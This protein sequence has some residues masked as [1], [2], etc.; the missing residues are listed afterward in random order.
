MTEKKHFN[1]GFTAASLRLN[2]FVTVARHI[3]DGSPIDYINLLGAGK[4][5]TGSRMIHEYSKR[6]ATLTPL[7]LSILINGI[8]PLQ[9][10]IGFLAICKTYGFIRDFTVEV[11]RE[12]VLLFQYSLSDGDFISFLRRKT[13]LH[14]ELETITENTIY[15]LKQVTFKILEQAGIIDS[16]K[17]KIIQP[18]LVD[19]K[20]IE[21]FASDNKEWLKILLLSDTDINNA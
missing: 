6:I 14:P 21:A 15:K 9:K 11:V 20:V 7:Q 1:L 13:E 5:T 3:R 4:A 18:Q 8:L 2:D 12:K 17:S 19:K 16:V 10:Q